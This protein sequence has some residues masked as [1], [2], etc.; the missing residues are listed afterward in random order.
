[1]TF[2]EMQKDFVRTRLGV[3]S[4]PIAGVIVYSGIALA[5]LGLPDAYRNLA[6]FLGFWLIM[7]IGAVVM[8]LRSEGRGNPANPLNRLSVLVRWMVLATW[9]IH[10][11]VW[12]YAPTLFPITI[13]IAFSLH[14]IVFGWSMG[15]SVGLIHVG[16]RCALVLTAWSVCPDN[17]VGA[18]CA[19]VAAAYLFSILQLYRLGSR[20]IQP[21]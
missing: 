17:R 3:P 11:P 12:I 5:S 14:W 10:V 2:D 21:A 6:L 4:L 18:V 16:L 7:P 8:K 1:M 19:A 13:G 9:T 15:N 20:R